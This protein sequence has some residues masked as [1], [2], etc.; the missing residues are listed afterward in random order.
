MVTDGAQLLYWGSLRQGIQGPLAPLRYQGPKLGYRVKNKG[1]K[2]WKV[3]WAILG[4]LHC[5]C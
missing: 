5:R 2:C 1:K 4:C 3:N